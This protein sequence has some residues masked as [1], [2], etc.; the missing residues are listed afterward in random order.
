[1]EVESN[2]DDSDGT[3]G[4][5]PE[6]NADV[7]SSGL[8]PTRHKLPQLIEDGCEP[9]EHLQR[10]LLLEHPLLADNHSTPAVKSALTHNDHDP[11]EL[12]ILRAKVNIELRK[13]A[14]ATER[15]D[16]QL[17]QQA[18]PN[19]RR[20]LE[21]YGIKKLA[22]L[23]EVTIICGCEDDEA[24]MY[25]SL[26]L[27]LLGW[28]PPA[29]GLMNRK[30][31]PDVKISDFLENR[32]ER[33]ARLL[34]R[35]GPSKDDNVDRES[36]TKTLDEVRAGVLDGPFMSLEAT[37]LTN[38]C[39]VPRHGILE[40]H[41]DSTAASV[42]NIDDLL[43]GEQNM[44][45]GTLT[46]HRPTDAD[47]LVAQVRA[48]SEKFP[49]S[50]LKTWKSD[51]SKAFKQVPSCPTQVE[52]VVVAQY[53]P[54][55]KCVVYFIVYSQ[56]FGGKSAPLNF[57]RYPALL[58]V[59][60]AYLYLA[61]MTHC[62]DDVICIEI[63][64]TI[65]SSR[66]G[67]MTLTSLSGWLISQEKSPEPSSKMNV[68]GVCLDLTR[69]PSEEPFLYV[70]W[71]RLQSL[72][73]MILQILLQGLLGSGQAASLSGKLGFTITGTFGKVGR[74]KIRPILRRAYSSHRTIS[75]QLLC[76]LVWWRKFFRCYEPRPIPMCLRSLPT[77]ISYSDGEGSLAGVGVAA[78]CPWLEHPVAAYTR[79]PQ[80]VR[81]MWADLAGKPSYKDIFLIEAVGPLLILE[82]F[83]KLVKDALWIHFIDNSGSE[84]SL[85]SGSSSIDAGD[86]IV[87]MT[88]ERI[89]KRRLWP[90]FDRVESSAN[91][92][93]KLSR[94]K[95]SGPWRQVVEVQFPTTELMALAD[96]CRSVKI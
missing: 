46:A 34:K 55:E 81:D 52:Y 2:S 3:D 80:V 1:M 15:E 89:A 16:M 64:E 7:I 56:V 86:H 5:R 50:R 35:L 88:W 78:W 13:L 72:D 85:V 63:A 43:V 19:V 30:R 96:E 44:T 75:Y 82:A 67:W 49:R 71:A 40:M 24:V 4:E 39:V 51:F 76:C 74:A 84:A 31:P 10:A 54:I 48:I 59:C 65:D 20:V 53:S 32:A 73:K 26:G 17:L 60:M 21:A 18:H 28:A 77:I 38:P 95:S 25:L 22:F 11:G 45:V 93:D 94:G 14:A 91:P 69:T 12:N 8:Q 47:G 37:G 62:V 6:R 27:P 70:T 42:R 90:F 61:P 68:I 66:S 23:R 79:V 36:Y 92:V 9:D 83:P 41:G 33:N 57:S 29:R 87:G 58:M